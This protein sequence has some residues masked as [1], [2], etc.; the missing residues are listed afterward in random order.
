MS[1]GTWFKDYVYIPL[2]GNRKSKQRTYLNLFVVWFLTGLWH[3]ASWNFVL[4]GLYF[5]MIIAVEKAGLLKVL[6]KC[7]KPVRHLYVLFLL[8]IGWVLFVFDDFSIGVEYLGIMFGFKGNPLFDQQFFYYL[9]TNALLLIVL[10]VSS[11]PF[12]KKIKGIVLNQFKDRGKFI[13]EDIIITIIY[14][15]ILFLSTAYLADASYNP[16]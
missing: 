2:G 12:I 10:T 5:G 9:Y 15:S 1:L 11:T 14:F 4:W 13:Y 16:F 3:G 8:I 7:S 6:E